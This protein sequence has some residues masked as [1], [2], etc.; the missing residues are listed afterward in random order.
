[1]QSPA[2]VKDITEHV[3]RAE[4]VQGYVSQLRALLKADRSAANE[5]SYNSIIKQ[6]IG[7]R[8]QEGSTG[9]LSNTEFARYIEDL[10]EYGPM[11]GFKN[12]RS[13]LETMQGGNPRLSTLDALDKSLRAGQSAKFG[14]YG[15]QMDEPPKP[16]DDPLLKIKGLKRVSP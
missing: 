1:M 12:W 14:A 6:L 2:N 10:P 16:D 9:V 3:G 8:S 5:A 7:D 15:I 4:Q 11:G 13:A